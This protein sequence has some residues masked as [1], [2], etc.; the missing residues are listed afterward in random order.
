MII[1]L[2]IVTL[3]FF[4]GY[5]FLPRDLWGYYFKDMERFY[6]VAAAFFILL[7]VVLLLVHNFKSLDFPWGFVVGY[8]L[9]DPIGFWMKEY[10]RIKREESNKPR[11]TK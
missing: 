1:F 11:L 8:W 4:I 5:L 10:R 3:C 9:I 6:I 2:L 7:I